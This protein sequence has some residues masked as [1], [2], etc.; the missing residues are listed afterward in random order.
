MLLADQATAQAA[1]RRRRL[2]GQ[3][4]GALVASGEKAVLGVTKHGASSLE[5]RERLAVAAIGDVVNLEELHILIVCVHRFTHLRCHATRVH[6]GDDTND[7]AGGEH[8]KKQHSNIE[9]ENSL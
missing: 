1:N 2:L 4:D 8:Q 7:H 9:R 5:A 6:G 3:L